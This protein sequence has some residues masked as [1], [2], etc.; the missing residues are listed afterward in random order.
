M[1]IKKVYLPKLKG[2]VDVQ[3]QNI[4]TRN[5]SLVEGRS[6]NES[7]SQCSNNTGHLIETDTSKENHLEIHVDVIIDNNG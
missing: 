6:G 7:T 5:S 1:S 2:S 3:S 4:K